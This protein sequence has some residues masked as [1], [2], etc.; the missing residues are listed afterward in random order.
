M[1][2][3]HKSQWSL[4]ADQVSH[5]VGPSIR[6]NHNENTLLLREGELGHPEVCEGRYTYRPY[7]HQ[8]IHHGDRAWYYTDHGAD[9]KEWVAML[10]GRT[11]H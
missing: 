7:R 10:E 3:C 4:I 2:Q 8:Q 9:Q 1:V 5:Y 11:V 6:S